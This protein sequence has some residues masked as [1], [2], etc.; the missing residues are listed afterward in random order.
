MMNAFGIS[1]GSN[2]EFSKN[3][4]TLPMVFDDEV[5]SWPVRSAPDSLLTPQHASAQCT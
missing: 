2:P 5:M 1:A 3:S 4:R